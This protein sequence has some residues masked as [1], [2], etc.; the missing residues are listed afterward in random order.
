MGGSDAPASL[1]RPAV[2]KL[3]DHWTAHMDQY[4]TMSH[5]RYESALP[6]LISSQPYGNELAISRIINKAPSNKQASRSPTVRGISPSE[7][8]RQLPQWSLTA[9]SAYGRDPN[10]RSQQ[11]SFLH[12]EGERQKTPSFLA[13]PS[14]SYGYAAGL[15]TP[16]AS[17]WQPSY[18]SSSARQGDTSPVQLP[19][20]PIHALAHPRSGYGGDQTASADEEELPDLAHLPPIPDVDLQHARRCIPTA[21]FHFFEAPSTKNQ[22]HLDVLRAR[23]RALLEYHRLEMQRGLAATSSVEERPAKRKAGSQPLLTEEAK[24]ANH[25]AS[26]QKRRANI[27]KGYEMLCAVVPALRDQLPRSSEHS[28][29]PDFDPKPL[30]AQ[31][32]AEGRTSSRSEAHMLRMSTCTGHAD[33]LLTGQVLNYSSDV[34][35]DTTCSC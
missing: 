26:E 15:P 31:E 34:S 28:V 20:F 30:F 24:R 32:L 21:L 2:E 10:W 33:G 18:H 12:A 35:H 6:Y 14:S 23:R 8:I 22:P 16:T 17:D 3:R 25:I 27:R 5:P 29:T 11:I 13:G 7:S 9:P 4:D 19:A 1:Q